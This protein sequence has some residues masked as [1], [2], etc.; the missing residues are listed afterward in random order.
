MKKILLFLAGL[1]GISIPALWAQEI[2]TSVV[3][4]AGG[5]MNTSNNHV[6]FSIGEIVI[7][8]FDANNNLIINSGILNSIYNTTTS[9]NDLNK[10]NLFIQLYPNPSSDMVVVNGKLSAD[11]HIRIFDITGRDATNWYFDGK[12]IHVDKL[13]E[14]YYFICFT[15]KDGNISHSYKFIKQ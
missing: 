8:S 13:Q 9:T 14:G 10:E 3:N 11:A 4:S 2:K 5:Y 15:N 7:K 6:S 1:C 12:L